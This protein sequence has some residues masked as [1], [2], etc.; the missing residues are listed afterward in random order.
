M[1]ATPTARKKLRSLSYNHI[2]RNRSCAPTKVAVMTCRN[3]IVL[4][5]SADQLVQGSLK[6][7]LKELIDAAPTDD[8]AL[9]SYIG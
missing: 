4:P 5:S 2:K 1:I 8:K 7:E 9:L 6:D 3:H